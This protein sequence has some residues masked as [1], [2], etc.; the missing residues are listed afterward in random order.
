M[1][2]G[3]VN[4]LGHPHGADTNAAPSPEKL[5]NLAQQFEALLIGEMLKTIREAAKDSGSD[6]DSDS[7]G[8]SAMDMAQTQF[9]QSIAAQGGLGLSH[10]IE[11]GLARD[12]AN[13]K[14]NAAVPTSAGA[15]S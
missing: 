9:A 11:T 13:Q 12:S 15:K 1:T 5:H 3:S 8:E 14:V 10:M 4:T 6:D 7:G 2:I